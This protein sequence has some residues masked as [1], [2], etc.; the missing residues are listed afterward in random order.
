MT[1][2]VTGQLREVLL[3]QEL[4]AGR[5]ELERLAVRVLVVAPRAKPVRRRLADARHGL[6]RR[7][8][9]H[10]REHGCAQEP[11]AEGAIEQVELVATRDER[12]PE[13]EEDVLLPGEV[14]G[15]ERAQRVGD[16]T[17]AHL[18]PGLVQH[19]PERDDV[20][21]DGVARGHGVR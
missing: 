20:P 15:V 7:P 6:R 2:L 9:P 17:R 3:P 10:R 1:Q 8:R 14:D 13:G 19:A 16:P 4:V 18:E 12:L 21:D 5:A 11:G